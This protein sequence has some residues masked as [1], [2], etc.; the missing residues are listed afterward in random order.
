MKFD[1]ACTLR[2]GELPQKE[3]VF[4][5]AGEAVVVRIGERLRRSGFMS[6]NQMMKELLG[7]R[8]TTGHS[9]AAL[10]GSAAACFVRSGLIA[11]ISLRVRS[12]IVMQV[13]IDCPPPILS[14]STTVCM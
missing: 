9:A 6:V 2:R 12:L 3:I 7:I 5:D 13:V 10:M 11:T 14:T 8:E 1:S 4:G